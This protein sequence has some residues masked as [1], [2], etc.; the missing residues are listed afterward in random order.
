ME[1]TN[2]TPRQVKNMASIAIALATPAC[3]MNAG[4]AWAPL[5]TGVGCANGSTTDELASAVVAVAATVAL[6]LHDL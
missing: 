1:I 6:A 3:M 2:C 5:S 4:D